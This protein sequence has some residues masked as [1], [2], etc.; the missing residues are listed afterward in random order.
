MANEPTVRERK[1]MLSPTAGI[2]GPEGQRQTAL[3]VE[4]GAMRGA[5]AA[6]VLAFAIYLFT[7]PRRRAKSR[8]RPVPASSTVVAGSGTEIT[9]S[10]QGT[11]AETRP[12]PLRSP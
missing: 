6:G 9:L 11:K 5:W 4:G 8:T 3:I 12:E 2:A 10:I 1:C 7:G